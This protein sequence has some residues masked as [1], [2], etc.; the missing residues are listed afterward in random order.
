MCCPAGAN[1]AR[2]TYRLALV[3]QYHLRIG[4]YLAQT[5][6]ALNQEK[7]ASEERDKAKRERK[8]A[9][10][11]EEIAV[12]QKAR[13]EEQR[14]K[15]M[16][17]K[18]V[19]GYSLAKFFEQ[20]ALERLEQAESTNNSGHFK[21][22]WQFAMAALQEE[23][24]PDKRALKSSSVGV[25][26]DSTVIK[27]ALANLWTSPT[28][29]QHWS[30][31]LSV[32]FSPDGTMLASGSSDNTVRLWEVAL[33]QLFLQEGRSTQLFVQFN[34]GVLFLWQVKQKGLEFRSDYVPSLFPYDGYHF[35]YDKKFRPL[36]NPP[37][38]GQSKFDQVLEWAQAQLTISATKASH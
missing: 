32:A 1:P 24:G 35:V 29:N 17:Q 10:E 11:Q 36:L 28:A 23:V 34:E 21:E 20:K 19:T 31:I 12:W 25:L 33:Y 8:R 30:D 3:F 7:I 5:Q 6:I 18:L 13:T 26:F 4:K 2:A 14:A 16:K 38:H 15:L 9:S 27:S 37:S 22:A